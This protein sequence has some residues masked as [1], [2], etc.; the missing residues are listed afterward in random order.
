MSNRIP[1]L[2]RTAG[3]IVCA[4]SLAFSASH[5]LAQE[6]LSVGKAGREAFSFVP[7]DIGDRLGFFKKHN[8][9]GADIELRR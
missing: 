6:T 7:V 2:R 9:D 1:T 5:A 3:L 8:L 4:A